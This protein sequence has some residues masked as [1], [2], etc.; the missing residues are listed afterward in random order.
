MV[1]RGLETWTAG[2]RVR[3]VQVYDP[4]SLRRHAGGPSDFG[5]RLTG[6]FLHIP[7]R[8]GK[9]L[10]VP[11]DSDPTLEKARST[12]D[13]AGEAL[14]IHLGMSG[15]VLIQDAEAHGEKHL[16][17]LLE[18]EPSQGRPT[19]L[20][21]VDQ[22]IF[23]G[24]QISAL[25]PSSHPSGWVPACAAHIARDPFELTAGAEE[26]FNALRR[27]RT[28]L[29]RA[30]LD[31]KLMSGI[32]NIYADEALWRARLHYAR[33]TDTVTRRES[34]R[35]LEAVRQVMEAALEAGGTS[36]DSLY[37]N[38]NGRS[39]Y[40]SRSLQ[41]YG[42]QGQLCSRCAGGER[43]GTIR[44]EAFMGRSSYWCPTCQPRPRVRRS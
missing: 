20:R 6:R 41:C 26:F 5:A 3:S 40:F 30:L 39:G 10:W 24:M 25:I 23:G 34:A 19:Q 44:R 7:Q 22:R 18:V 4:R 17:I 38:V 33:R 2:R 29:K 31:Q 27:R 13:P 42:R 43:P 28:D 37:V 14:V 8:R 35:L 9:F 21:F 12:Q 1:R 36:F 11:L 32:G 15:Q 16:R